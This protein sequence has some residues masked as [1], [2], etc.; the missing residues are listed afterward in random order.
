[1]EYKIIQKK[2]KNKLLS[3]FSFESV[4][5]FLFISS[6]IVILIILTFGIFDLSIINSLFI[7]N[8]YQKA[9]DVIKIVTYLFAFIK[10]CS[11]LI[12]TRITINLLKKSIWE[13]IINNGK[14][15]PLKLFTEFVIGNDFITLIKY[16]KYID[17]YT[18]IYFSIYIFLTIIIFLGNPTF[19]NSFLINNGTSVQGEICYNKVYNLSSQWIEVGSSLKLIDKINN[20]NN[21]NKWNLRYYDDNKNEMLINPNINI[22]YNKY[23]EKWILNATHIDKPINNDNYPFPQNAFP[24]NAFLNETL[25]ASQQWS[26]QY[27]PKRQI[28]DKNLNDD[29]YN[30]AYITDRKNNV[31]VWRNA[32]IIRI[33]ND[34]NMDNKL[35]FDI[36]SIYYKLSLNKTMCIISLGKFDEKLL[37]GTNI[38][39]VNEILINLSNNNIDYDVCLTLIRPLLDFINLRISSQ[40][41]VNNFTASHTFE[42]IINNPVKFLNYSSYNSNIYSDI[43]CVYGPN[44]ISVYILRCNLKIIGTASILLSVIVLIILFMNIKKTYISIRWRNILSILPILYNSDSLIFLKDLNIN[45]KK[46]DKIMIN[47]EKEITKD[48]Y[49]IKIKNYINNEESI[50]QE[51]ID[52]KKL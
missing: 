4:G 8:E 28:A 33:N 52:I 1:M 2:D 49:E 15:I 30:Y 41:M 25:L 35:I 5:Y 20:Y 50:I 43:N 18:F 39:N 47:F 46:L 12:I 13:N 6:L 48:N 9:L 44:I 51:N 31:N 11:S 3:N 14:I 40:F 7:F 23:K 22:I 17:I 27:L 21:T 36:G 16:Y 29:I 24:Q 10:I 45:D 19:S 38:A 42:E 26:S 34:I 32:S 37:N